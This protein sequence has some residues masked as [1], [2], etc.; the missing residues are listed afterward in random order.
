MPTLSEL[1]AQQAEIS[2]QIEEI[3]QLE[4]KNA[5]TQ[6]LK[7][8]SDYDLTQDDLFNSLNKAKKI[9]TKSPAM[10]RDP[11]SKKEWTGKGQAPG[12]M[13]KDAESRIAFLIVQP[14]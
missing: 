1:I 7:L 2:K 11:V 5:I 12:W 13:P 4:R 10:Y 14:S 3:R 8:I 6:I 9:T